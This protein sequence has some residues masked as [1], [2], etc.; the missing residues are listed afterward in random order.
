VILEK[1]GT[2]PCPEEAVGEMVLVLADL[3]CCDQRPARRPAV[4][5]VRSFRT[6]ALLPRPIVRGTDS[7]Y[8]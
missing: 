5:V 6:A 1:D 2:A 3:S 7:Q 8:L 4:D